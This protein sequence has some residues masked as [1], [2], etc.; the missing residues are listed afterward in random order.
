MK[1]NQFYG[2]PTAVRLLLKYGDTWVK[3]YDRSSLRTLG[4]GEHCSVAG[5][6]MCF[7]CQSH[8]RLLNGCNHQS[9]VAMSVVNS[10]N[11]RPHRVGSRGLAAPPQSPQQ[12]TVWGTALQTL[13]VPILTGSSLLWPEQFLR[14]LRGISCGSQLLFTEHSPVLGPDYFQALS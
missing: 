13:S 3:K 11:A 9:C 7:V 5:G 12:L 1:I 8:C 2:A 6:G 4:S 10:D 14:W